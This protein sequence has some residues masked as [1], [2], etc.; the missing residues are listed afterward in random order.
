MSYG[1]GTASRLTGLT[2]HTIRAWESRYQ[3]VAAQ[4]D[5]AGR[6]RYSPA[7][8]ER[9]TK[10]K[11]LTDLG[12]RIG[13]LAGLAETALDERLTALGRDKRPALASLPRLKVGVY[14]PGA[15]ALTDTLTSMKGHWSLVTTQ[16]DATPASLLSSP[17]DVDCLIVEQA[18]LAPGNVETLETL[19]REG[20]QRALI[21]IYGFARDQD[22]QRLAQ[23]GTIILRAPA[24][25]ADLKRALDE[26]T[27]QRLA[28]DAL[29]Q[30][31]PANSESAERPRFSTAELTRIGQVST[32]IDC[33]CPHH[34]VTLLSNL[35]A[36]E[37]YS[38]DCTSRNIDDA[39]MHEFLYR[40]TV[41][42]NLIMESA[43]RELIEY[44]GIDVTS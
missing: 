44:E 35:R 30:V 9:L 22:L 13:G 32:S 21:V 26:V 39:A 6:R 7:D 5:G 18:S 16:V 4:R 41:R 36:F 33:E 34:L 31:A 1:I 15:S 3:A 43:L 40:E 23:S 37:R 17:P 12:E 20:S 14:G 25:A 24:G 2:T 42:A 29:A 11:Q 28:A 19:S 27:Q 38:A 8:V 10:L